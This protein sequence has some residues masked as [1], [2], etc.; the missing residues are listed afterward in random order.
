MQFAQAMENHVTEFLDSPAF[1]RGVKRAGRAIMPERNIFQTS[2]SDM[3]H[4]TS[5][6]A[7]QLKLVEDEDRRVIKKA[8]GR[9]NK[10][11]MAASL[12]FLEALHA[13]RRLAF[14]AKRPTSASEII[15]RIATEKIHA[16]RAA[17]PGTDVIPWR[18]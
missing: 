12:N 16:Q 7:E 15:R 17:I 13:D 18:F 1:K 2:V 10:A 9:K 6:Q 5:Y 11:E 4:P 14:Q 8:F 3:L